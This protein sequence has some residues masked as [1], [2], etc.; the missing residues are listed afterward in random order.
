MFGLFN[1]F[2]KK[3]VVSNDSS[4][5]IN[6]SDEY[7]TINGRNF[8]VPMH[9]DGLIEV[10]GSPRVIKCKTD[11]KDRDFLE[12]MHGE[13]MVTNRVNYV[14]DEL[15]INCYTM[16]GKIITC[17]GIE[18]N[19]GTKYP[20]TPKK[21]FTGTLTICNRHWL[22]AIRLGEDCEVLQ[23]LHLGGYTLTAEYVDFDQDM[24]TRDETSYT[25]IEISLKTEMDDMLNT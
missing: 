8:E 9:V 6:I 18:L 25:G 3:G 10:L 4:C 1:L 15:G 5:T 21:V 19:H 17:I 2:K 7:I 22:D 14:W 23:Q 12:K 11:K 20:Q 13:G 24:A 16:N